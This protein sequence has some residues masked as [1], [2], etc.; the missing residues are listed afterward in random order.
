MHSYVYD[1]IHQCVHCCSAVHCSCV[2]AGKC[3]MPALSVRVGVE[4]QSQHYNSH[5]RSNCIPW[6]KQGPSRSL[7]EHNFATTVSQQSLLTRWLGMDG[8]CT[9]THP[10]YSVQM[11][12]VGPTKQ[13]ACQVCTTSSKSSGY[14]AQRIPCL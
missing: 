8:V 9:H 10:M 12:T 5:H 1:I 6:L 7:A 11:Q 13:Q 3:R 2:T 4:V 14:N